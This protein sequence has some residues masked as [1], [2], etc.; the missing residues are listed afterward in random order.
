MTCTITIPPRKK[1]V[2]ANRLGQLSRETPVMVWPGQSSSIDTDSHVAE[3]CV[4]A[5]HPTQVSGQRDLL[6]NEQRVRHSVA[7]VHLPN[8]AVQEERTVVVR[9]PGRRIVRLIYRS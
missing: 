9:A 4:G 7:H 5:R 3:R 1:P 6:A 2:D 8:A